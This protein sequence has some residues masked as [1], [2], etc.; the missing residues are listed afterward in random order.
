VLGIILMT[1]FQGMS[2]K[3]MLL[4]IKMSKLL[5]NN[6]A[7]HPQSSNSFYP[8]WQ[9]ICLGQQKLPAAFA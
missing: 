9:M 1:L 7:D 3:T 2:D 8:L 4:N 6:N 5:I